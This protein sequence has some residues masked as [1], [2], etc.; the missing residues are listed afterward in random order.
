MSGLAASFTSS[1]STDIVSTADTVVDL[2]EEYIANTAYQLSAGVITC[3]VAGIYHV[4]YSLPVNDDGSTGA[5]RCRVMAW[6]ERNPGGVGSFSVLKNSHA[7]DYA[8]E[9][10]GGAGLSTAFQV[11]ITEGD[12]LRLMVRSSSTTD[13]STESGEA[14]LSLFRI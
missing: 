8:R 13:I 4:S 5:Q 7:Q 2:D 11:V 9:A 6:L 12:E 10:S 1:G 3:A 14:Q